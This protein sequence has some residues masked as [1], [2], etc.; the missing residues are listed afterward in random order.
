MVFCE[1]KGVV[2]DFS[3]LAANRYSC[4]KLDSRP[5]EPELIQKILEAQRLAPTAHNLQPQ[6]IYVLEGDEAFATIA[7]ATRYDFGARLFFVVCYDREASWKRKFDGFDGG[8]MDAV[9]AGCHLDFA[10]AD[11]GLGSCW[12]ANF[13]PDKLREAME[14]PEHHVPMAI[15]PVGYP[16][17]EAKPSPS[18]FDRKDLSH[19]VI[20]C[21]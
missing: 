1:N 19:T 21:R 2:M 17:E 8:L 5:V 9:I 6:R 10:I 18:H 15:F 7:K 12:I 11:A 16:T 3:S 20:D 13:D 4:R 14:L